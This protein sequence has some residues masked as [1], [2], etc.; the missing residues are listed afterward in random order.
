MLSVDG[1]ATCAVQNLRVGSDKPV[2]YGQFNP[3]PN[4]LVLQ[5]APACGHMDVLKACSITNWAALLLRV[6]SDEDLHSLGFDSSLMDLVTEVEQM[7]A[8]KQANV[9]SADRQPWPAHDRCRPSRAAL[10]HRCPSTQVLLSEL[11]S[12]VTAGYEPCLIGER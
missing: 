1:T 11:I 4:D 10:L 6:E 3:A 12:H 5:T 7:V 9:A 8:Y 2:P